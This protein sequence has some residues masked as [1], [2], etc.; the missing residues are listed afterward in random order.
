LVCAGVGWRARFPA[1]RGR[2]LGDRRVAFIQPRAS[3]ARALFPGQGCGRLLV[4]DLDNGVTT[5]VAPYAQAP[6]AWSADSRYLASQDTNQNNADTQVI[7]LR[8]RR[9]ESSLFSDRR[10]MTSCRSRSP[11]TTRKS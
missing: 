10:W 11:Q 3:C 2:R 6:I 5:Q 9:D 8:N 7:R 1:A 4:A